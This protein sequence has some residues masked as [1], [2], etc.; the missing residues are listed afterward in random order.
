MDYNKIKKGRIQMNEILTLFGAIGV[1][2]NF[3]LFIAFVVIAILGLSNTK[4]K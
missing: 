1:C 4:M 3:V 2:F